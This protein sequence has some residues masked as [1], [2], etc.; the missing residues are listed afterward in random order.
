M[1]LA[2]ILACTTVALIVSTGCHESKCPMTQ[3]QQKVNIPTGFM[4]K[5]IDFE[6]KTYLYGLYV[7]D[8]YTPNRAW[9]AVLFLHGMGE[10]GTDGVVQ[11][12][13]GIGPAI[14]ANPERYPC[15]VVM[16]QCPPDSLWSGQALEMAMATLEQTEKEYR[17]DR[18][19]TVLT[20][21][22]M[23]GFGTWTLGAQKPDRFCALLPV[24]GG[25]DPRDA[26]TLAQTPIWCF[27]G[28]ADP[29]VPVARSREMVEAVR[30]AGGS[31]RYTEYPEVGHNAWD[32][33]Y[34]DPQVPAWMLDPS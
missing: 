23:G 16:P 3:E 13:V 12:N 29:V 15:I 22:S 9:P 11:T 25:G 32:P 34:Q 6:G 14:R 26:Q 4:T 19:R 7:P 28:A 31:I 30:N 33:T 17:T 2:S 10:R 8:D 5:S 27:H 24:C 21:L 20:G 18:A 1:K